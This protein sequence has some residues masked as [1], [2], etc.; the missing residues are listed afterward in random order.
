MRI[1]QENEFYLRICKRWNNIERNIYRNDDTHQC[2]ALQWQQRLVLVIIKSCITKNYSKI[3]DQEHRYV[4]KCSHF[5][6][7]S[8][9]ITKHY[10]Q[11]TVCKSSNEIPFFVRRFCQ[12]FRFDWINSFFDSLEH[13]D[14]FRWYR[15]GGIRGIINVR[16]S[17]QLIEACDYVES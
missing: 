5:V 13:V 15:I 8:H 16:T 6:V 4:S 11:Y 1:Y 9:K 14:C 2:Q 17:G 3:D 10:S 12:V 7:L